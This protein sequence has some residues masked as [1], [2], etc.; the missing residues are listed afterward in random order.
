MNPGEGSVDD[1]REEW[2][3]DTFVELADTLV[4][5]FDVVEFLGMLVARCAVLLDGSEVGLAVANRQGRLRVLASSSERMRILELLEVQNEEGPCRDCY[6]TGN[7]ILNKR[8]DAAEPEWPHFAPMARD[9]GFQM[10]HAVPMRLRGQTI[11]A[12]NIFDPRPRNLSVHTVN[13]TQ[14]FADVAT[15]GILQERSSKD[16]MILAA[17]LAKALDT[18]VAIEQAKGV[19]AERLKIGMDEGFSLLRGYARSNNLRL[20]DV[21]QAVT[22]GELPSTAL[23]DDHARRVT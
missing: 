1:S 3:A 19:L 20:S 12:I 10:L 7:Q 2:L 15:I 8:V 18:R 4:A 13:M 11:G 22:S 9:A 16:Q 6:L 14:A 5:D 23:V 21:A 17:Q